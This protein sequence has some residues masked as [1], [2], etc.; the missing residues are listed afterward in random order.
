MKYPIYVEYGLGVRK[1][2]SE[3]TYIAVD[4]DFWEEGIVRRTSVRNVVDTLLKNGNKI[5]EACFNNAFQNALT[6]L[7]LTALDGII[8]PDETDQERIEMQDRSR[9]IARG[10]EDILVM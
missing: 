9:E 5:S 3:E 4:N 7:Y 2:E 8:K 10:D 6:K 1:I